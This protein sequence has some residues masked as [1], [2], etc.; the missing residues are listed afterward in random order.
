MIRGASVLCLCT[1][2]LAF[3]Q[4]GTAR[5]ATETFKVDPAHTYPGFGVLHLGISTQ[6]GR[7]ERTAGHIALDRGARTGEIVI[8]IE[9]TSLSTGNF[10]LDKALRGEDFFNVERFPRM[11]FQSQRLEFE[12]DVPRHAVGELTLLGVTRPVTLTIERFGCTRKPL[13]IRTTCGADVSTT[14]SRSAFGMTNYLAW[15][16]DDVRIDIQIE[17][18]KE[19]A[20]VEPAPSGG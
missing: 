6:R 12:R 19:E 8:E 11:V 9:T 13:L 5:S 4:P 2:A 20:A 3:A 7:F 1:A 16:A 14:I 10:V 15:I 17:A 18:V